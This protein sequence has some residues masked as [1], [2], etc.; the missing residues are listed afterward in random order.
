[1]APGGK[2]GLVCFPNPTGALVFNLYIPHLFK[3]PLS[4]LDR[5]NGLQNPNNPRPALT[6]LP[7]FI[8]QQLAHVA[9]DASALGPHLLAKRGGKLTSDDTAF[10]KPFAKGNWEVNHADPEGLRLFAFSTIIDA[11]RGVRV[12]KVEGRDNWM[13]EDAEK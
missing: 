7:M 12:T 13:K 5:P 8:L 11:D 10:L 9:I 2:L 1:M 6:I 3:Q 4:L